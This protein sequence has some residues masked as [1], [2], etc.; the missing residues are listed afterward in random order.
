MD[1]PFKPGLG[2]T[3]STLTL[4]TAAAATTSSAQPRTTRRSWRAKDWAR[5]TQVLSCCSFWHKQHH[6]KEEKFEIVV[7]ANAWGT[8]VNIMEG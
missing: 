8:C 4:V 6:M 2:T 1:S 5:P 7:F 3:Q